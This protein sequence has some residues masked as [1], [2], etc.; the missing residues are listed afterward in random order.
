MFY[1]GDFVLHYHVWFSQIRSHILSQTSLKTTKVSC[2]FNNTRPSVLFLGFQY[3]ELRNTY[4][5]IPK[6]ANIQ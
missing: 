4:K 6:N 2:F 5:W 3:F 1:A